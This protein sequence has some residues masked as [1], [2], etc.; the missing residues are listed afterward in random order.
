MAK[1]NDPS[2]WGRLEQM[3]KRYNELES[4]GAKKEAA[5]IY[6][7]LNAFK[8]KKGLKPGFLVQQGKYK[9]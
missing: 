3:A 6:E 9:F 1:F 8:L 2:T 5:L 7:A 4:S